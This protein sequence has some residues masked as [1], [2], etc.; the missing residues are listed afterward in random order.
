MVSN[1]WTSVCVV[2]T[3]TARYLGLFGFNRTETTFFHTPRAGVPTLLLMT[4]VSG[5]QEQY[6][7]ISMVMC[8][9]D[10]TLKDGNA[11]L[12]IFSSKQH[13]DDW[14]SQ[15]NDTS[16]DAK[17]VTVPLAFLAPIIPEVKDPKTEVM[18]GVAW[19]TRGDLSDTHLLY[20]CVF[21][22]AVVAKNASMTAPFRVKR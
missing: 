5:S 11:K 19:A 3:S 14:V 2:S 16:R 22:N 8:K 10:D 6:K 20:G 15:K 17:L 1:P 18:I 7:L 12:V 4:E 21:A 13:A 9:R